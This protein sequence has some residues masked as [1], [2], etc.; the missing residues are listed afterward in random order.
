M[1]YEHVYL[2]TPADGVALYKGLDSYF[3]FYNS[4]RLHQS[5]GYRAPEVLYKKAAA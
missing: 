4:E 5:L 1:K 3:T 2:Y